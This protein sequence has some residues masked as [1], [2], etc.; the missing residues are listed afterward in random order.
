VTVDRY[1]L[2]TERIVAV[3]KK[4]KSVSSGVVKKLIKIMM[5]SNTDCITNGMGDE[6]VASLSKIASQYVQFKDLAMYI[7]SILEQNLDPL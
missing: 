3:C 5:E 1:D 2:G 7:D 4:K 6:W